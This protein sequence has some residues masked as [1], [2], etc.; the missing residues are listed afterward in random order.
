MGSGSQNFFLEAVTHRSILEVVQL[1]P[2]NS[3][4]ISRGPWA[5]S[6]AIG[7]VFPCLRKEESIATHFRDSFQYFSLGNCTYNCVCLQ[8]GTLTLIDMYF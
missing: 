1:T 8:D 7:C 5:V 3:Q 4:V 6:C 2:A